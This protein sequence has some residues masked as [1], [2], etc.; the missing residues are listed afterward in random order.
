VQSVSLLIKDHGQ[1]RLVPQG[2][3]EASG[4]NPHDIDRAITM[5]G[6][7]EIEPK[8]T[9][10]K[11]R[12]CPESVAPVAFARMME[13]LIDAPIERFDF[14]CYQNGAWQS[15]IFRLSKT[16]L[17][18]VAALVRQAKD[19][20][21]RG[22]IRVRAIGADLT[23]TGPLRRALDF[24]RMM[25]GVWDADAM[26]PFLKRALAD[27]YALYE[28]QSDRDFVFRAVGSGMPACALA[29]LRASIGC[30]IEQ[31]PDN[32]YGQSC[33]EFYQRSV[34]QSVPGLQDVDALVWWPQHGRLRRRY[35]R[36]LLPFR[37]A[38]HQRLLLCVTAEDLTIDLR[39]AVA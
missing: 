29:A 3:D 20:V 36:L 25:S 1:I 16:S 8:R 38:D 24:W 26:S 17:H 9:W 34:E 19:A 4:F 2:A 27:R 28:C 39:A 18:R 21:G 7:V 30:R 31:L 5:L 14:C 11:I 37:D 12:L 6:F 15:R 32:A 33:A 13:W 35:K 10:A 23:P 22:D